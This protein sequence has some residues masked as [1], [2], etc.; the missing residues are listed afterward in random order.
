MAEEGE[1]CEEGK[2]N[3]GA[4]QDGQSQGSRYL[5]PWEVGLY[6]VGEY[7]GKE[8]TGVFFKNGSWTPAGVIKHSRGVGNFWVIDG[9]G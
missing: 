2:R 5:P 9:I 8:T 3:G 6:P 4:Q 7:T 1:K